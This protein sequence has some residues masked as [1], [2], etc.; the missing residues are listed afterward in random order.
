[1]DSFEPWETAIL[2]VAIFIC[3]SWT[4]FYCIRRRSSVFDSSLLYV[5]RV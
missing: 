2:C 3:V 4:L 5:S 1:M